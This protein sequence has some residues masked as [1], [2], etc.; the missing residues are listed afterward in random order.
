MVSMIFSKF[1]IHKFIINPLYGGNCRLIFFSLYM[2]KDFPIFVCSSK[3]WKLLHW[4]AFKAAIGQLLQDMLR[5]TNLAT[6]Q[7]EVD[8]V[9]RTPGH[10]KTIKYIIG[11]LLPGHQWLPVSPLNLTLTNHYHPARGACIPRYSPEKNS[12]WWWVAGSLRL[13][14]MSDIMV[15]LNPWVAGSP[16]DHFH[17]MIL[18]IHA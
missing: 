9:S 18:D 15:P 1:L 8:V 12:S 16:G 3:L 13:N 10:G 14:F 6:W 11:M 17:S 7:H 4:V 5:M 2:F